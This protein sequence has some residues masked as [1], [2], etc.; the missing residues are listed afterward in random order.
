MCEMAAGN[1]PSCAGAGDIP[2][3][4][5]D[6]LVTACVEDMN[7]G[8][9]LAEVVAKTDS[10]FFFSDPVNSAIAV[11]VSA[12][13]MMLEEF[14]RTTLHEFSYLMIFPD[15]QSGVRVFVVSG[16]ATDY[17]RQRSAEGSRTDSRNTDG[18]GIH[19]DVACTLFG[20][21]VRE[22]GR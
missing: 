17:A 1:T 5:E 8:D 22:P 4:V 7:I 6:Q 13:K 14:L 18:I 20:I 12:E 21:Q 11:S 15:S 10:A 9:V 2:I 19:G 3:L 16:P